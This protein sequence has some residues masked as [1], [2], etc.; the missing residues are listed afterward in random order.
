MLDST[1]PAHG[2]TSVNFTIIAK[3]LLSPQAVETVYANRILIIIT[4]TS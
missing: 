1:V 3:F 4:Y 2:K